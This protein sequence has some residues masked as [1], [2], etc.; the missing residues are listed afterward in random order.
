MP[1]HSQAALFLNK[2]S[3]GTQISCTITKAECAGWSED[4]EPSATMHEWIAN[5]WDIYDADGSGELDLEE[6]WAFVRD[7]MTGTFSRENFDATFE[8]MDTDQ[9]GALSQDELA[10]FV[11]N[12]MAE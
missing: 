9:S 10:R 1:P 6:A 11:T 3:E 2:N 5:L 7:N 12:L 8:L 4:R